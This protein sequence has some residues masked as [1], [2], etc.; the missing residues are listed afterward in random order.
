MGHAWPHDGD[1]S[2]K[3]SAKNVLFTEM[4]VLPDRTVRGEQAD[5]ACESRTTRSCPAASF[6]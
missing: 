6:V 5:L 1:P 3:L 2:A 4:S